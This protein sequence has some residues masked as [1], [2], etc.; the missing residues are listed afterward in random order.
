MPRHSLKVA[1]KPVHYPQK[2]FLLCAKLNMKL[3]KEKV[4]YKRY[5]T[6]IE[7]ALQ[8][9]NG[10]EIIW[11]VRGGDKI[12][13]AIVGIKTKNEIILIKGFKPR[14]N[15]YFID[16]P[17]GTTEKKEDPRQCALRELFYTI[18]FVS[19]SFYIG[20]RRVHPAIISPVLSY[21]HPTHL[22]VH[23]NI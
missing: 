12:G 17:G 11:G 4:V 16:I 23:Q 6:I 19:F 2:C 13:V 9:E 14:P 15:K 22:L 21:Y 20:S 10:N 8:D 3:I 5:R 7:R 18:L 1:T